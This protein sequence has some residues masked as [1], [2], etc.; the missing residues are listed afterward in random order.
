LEVPRVNLPRMD[1]QSVEIPFPY[2]RAA[3]GNA[4]VKPIDVKVST[5]K[6]ASRKV[7]R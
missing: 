4:E 5:L 1:L 6:V 3:R 2:A 7:A